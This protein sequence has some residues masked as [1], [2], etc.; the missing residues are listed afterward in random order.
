MDPRDPLTWTFKDRRARKMFISID[1]CIP[2]DQSGG[3]SMQIVGLNVDERVNLQALLRQEVLAVDV[4][5]GET[6][7]GDLLPVNLSALRLTCD[8]NNPTFLTVRSV[9]LPEGVELFVIEIAASLDLRRYPSGPAVNWHPIATLTDELRGSTIEDIRLLSA[10][11]Q[12]VAGD[13][14]GH[15]YYGKDPRFLSYDFRSYAVA[16]SVML[17]CLR[18]RRIASRMRSALAA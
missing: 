3:T 5:E 17:G 4:P 15:S 9:D 14:V 6:S 10:G 12:V 13:S 18:Y 7:S 2:A 8:D 1:V 11:W 16:S